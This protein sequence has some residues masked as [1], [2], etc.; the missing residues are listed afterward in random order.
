MEVIP[1]VMRIVSRDG[2]RYPMNRDGNIGI[3]WK[4]NKV[5]VGF[6]EG[7]GEDD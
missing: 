7:E 3:G 4:W 5:E 1:S 2:S 6:N